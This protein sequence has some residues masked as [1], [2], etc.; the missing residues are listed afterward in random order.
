MTRI[1]VDTREKQDEITQ[2]ITSLG[3]EW[4]YGTL[5]VGDYLLEKNVPIEYKSAGSGSFNFEFF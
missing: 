5:K 3:L 2:I 4:E 1:I